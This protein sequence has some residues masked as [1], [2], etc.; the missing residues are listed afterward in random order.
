VTSIS[1]CAFE[2]CSSLASVDI[3][4]SVT[5]IDDYAF[6]LCSSL[7]CVDIPTSVTS[8]G[9]HA[10]WK[11]VLLS[12]IEIPT[13]VASV[14]A[15]AFFECKSLS[16]VT[17][18]STVAD[19][20]ST[21]T[22]H[23]YA[24]KH[25]SRR[26]ITTTGA[27]GNCP[28]LALL[29][30]SPRNDGNAAAHAAA[31]DTAAT[32]VAIITA[33]NDA[34][35]F[36]AVT[37][38]WAT[39]DII[40]ELK[41]PF[42]AYNQFADLPLPL[43]AVPDATSFADGQLWLWWLPPSSFYGEG[44][45][46][47]V[48]CKS[49]QITIWVTMLSAYKSSEVLDLLPDLEPELWELIF[50]FLKHSQLPTCGVELA[51]LPDFS[52]A[53]AVEIAEGGEPGSVTWSNPPLFCEILCNGSLQKG[54]QPTFDIEITVSS[55]AT[56][57]VGTVIKNVAFWHLRPPALNVEK[58]STA[59]AMARMVPRNI[60]IHN[61]CLV[62]MADGTH[63]QAIDVV[64]G[65]MVMV[66]SN[67]RCE[68][69][70]DGRTIVSARVECTTHQ[71]IECGR[72]GMCKVSAGCIVT[73]EHP[74]MQAAPMLTTVNQDSSSNSS[75]NTTGM[76][77]VPQETL[78]TQQVAVSVLCNFMLE[79]GS[80]FSVQVGGID[81]ITLAHELTDP[82][83]AHPVWG[84]HA[85]RCYLRSQPSYPAIQIDHAFLNGLAQLEESIPTQQGC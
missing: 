34:N 15:N 60:C 80:G 23:S 59:E 12:S 3:P 72:A 82:K 37:K 54:G 16:I 69:D 6:A 13:A 22:T 9:S 58:E 31:A 1:A 30:I 41:G 73:P 78:P 66:T 27:F 62:A 26:R 76:W 74:Y 61:E 43:R 42:A 56:V 57:P 71:H 49:R 5:I 11:C 8:I 84:S 38:I 81:C 67:S 83:V 63:K 18:P 35:Q 14:G 45:D 77:M 50:T 68:T 19:L 10:F 7:T 4:T 79:R 51:S 29:I 33:F 65:D 21:A 48:V 32:S 70:V 24:R 40:K 47:R 85:L 28:A 52:H 55:I 64:P 46:D 25:N 75:N 44:N 53:A 39:D 17:I 20:S 2:G 36:P